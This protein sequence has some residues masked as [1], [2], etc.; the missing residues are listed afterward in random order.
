MKNLEQVSNLFRD[1]E[2]VKVVSS[3]SS[4]GELHSIVAGSVMVVDDDTMAVAEV[5]M[6]TTSANLE[7]NNKVA[8]LG[9]KGM[10][11]YLLTGT[12]QKRSTDGDLYNALA[13]RFAAMKMQ[14]KGVWTFNVEKIYNESAG[15]DAGKQIY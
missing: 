8:I 7:A 14:I 15:P 6:Q 2:S 13:E 3:V 10:E 5:M 12:V 1:S 9:V 4:D 11:S